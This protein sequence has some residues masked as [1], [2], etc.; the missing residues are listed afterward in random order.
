MLERH[1]SDGGKHFQKTID[2]TIT[3]F[4][5]C[6]FSTEIWALSFVPFIGRPDCSKLVVSHWFSMNRHQNIE[7]FFKIR[8][9]NHPNNFIIQFWLLLN[10]MR[11]LPNNPQFNF[12]ILFKFRHT[13]P[14]NF[15]T[16]ALNLHYQSS[17]HSLIHFHLQNLM[18]PPSF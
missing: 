18:F 12:S 8:F 13:T 7:N 15:I 9:K 1:G 16:N 5:Q 4:F 17:L 10:R 2:D 11:E 3:L 6:P 14:A